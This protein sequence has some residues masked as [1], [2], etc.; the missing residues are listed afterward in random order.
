MDV[1]ITYTIYNNKII[2]LNHY[3]VIDTLN[4]DR[5]ED[6]FAYASY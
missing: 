6:I 3:H 1:T 2:L 5:R 4:T